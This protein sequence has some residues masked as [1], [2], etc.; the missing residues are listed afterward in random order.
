MIQ[1]LGKRVLIE[2]IDNEEKKTILIVKEEPK[3]LFKVIAV[4]DEVTKVKPDDKIILQ[5]FNKIT[6][7]FLGIDHNLCDEADILGKVL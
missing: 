5:Y 6:I 4:G 7:P 1:P 3:L 2:P